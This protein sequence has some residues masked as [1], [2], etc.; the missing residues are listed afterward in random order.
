MT[1]E[2]HSQFRQ[3]MNRAGQLTG[4]DRL[5]L[6]HGRAGALHVNLHDP[7]AGWTPVPSRR[8][9]PAG[10][11]VAEDGVQHVE[12]LPLLD[13]GDDPLGVGTPIRTPPGDEQ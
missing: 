9:W 6:L 10:R 4:G 8:T 3:V 2:R 11:G 5:R 12:R 7:A 13:G 1:H